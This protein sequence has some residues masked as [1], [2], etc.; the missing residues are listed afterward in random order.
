M[1]KPKSEGGKRCSFHLSQ[2]VTGGVTAYA[3]SM[4][5]LSRDETKQAFEALQAE[6]AH[7]P[8]PEQ[9]EVD[10]FLVAESFRVQ[11]EP[12]LTEAKRTSILNR[13]RSAIGKV[14]PDGATFHAW[15][16]VVAEAWARSRRRAVGV[17]LI[18]GL[19]FGVGGCA[20]GPSQASTPAPSGPVATASVTPG[21]STSAVV[22]AAA[23][24]IEKGTFTGPAVAEY[25][26]ANVDA[27]YET[28]AEFAAE[29]AVNSKVINTPRT[30][31]K[32]A[33]LA[34]VKSMMTPSAAKSWDQNAANPADQQSLVNMSGVVT[35]GVNGSG[36]STRTDV[37]QPSVKISDGKASLDADG[38]LQLT[39]EV[40]HDLRVNVAGG[41][42]KK[43]NFD[44]TMTYWL[45]KGT[46]KDKPWLID[47]WQAQYHG[48]QPVADVK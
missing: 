20:T 43:F 37:T 4:T 35:Y 29:N 40:G 28:M 11:H 38:R 1:C 9:P 41:Q 6:G 18:S 16:N 22:K 8:A 5:G 3:A 27:A 44:R 21:Q 10:G 24:T 17:F 19:A 39:F 2:G 15:K 7:L 48:A 32:A 26:K 42:Y 12:S 23:P 30:Q 36:T 25:G 31:V 13:L 14:T 34:S 47:G 33:D 46:T 45:V